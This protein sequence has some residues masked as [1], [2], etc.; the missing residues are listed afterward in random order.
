MGPVD[1]YLAQAAAAVGE[2]ELAARHADR[3]LELMEA[4]QIPLAA[5]WMRGQRERFSF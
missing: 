1:A 4:W 5:Q 3:A 2:A